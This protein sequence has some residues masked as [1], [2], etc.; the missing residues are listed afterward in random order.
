MLAEIE[1]KFKGVLTNY[2]LWKNTEFHSVQCPDLA[3]K[4]RCLTQKIGAG[5]VPKT[6]AL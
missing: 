1:I 4:L 5:V 6:D 2:L 3:K